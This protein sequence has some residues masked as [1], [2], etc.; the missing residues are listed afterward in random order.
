MMWISIDPSKASTGVALWDGIE[1]KDSL[2]IKPRG[3]KGAY[4]FENDVVDCRA[5]AY[6]K[7][8]GTVNC[9]VER[10]FIER[11][12]GGMLNAVRAQGWMCGYIAACFELAGMSAPEE[13]VVSEWRR[14]ITEDCGISWPANRDRKK[15]LAID[16][17]KQL[18]GRT[19]DNDDE[20]DA[21]LLGRAC[22]RMFNIK[23]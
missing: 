12:A 11:G 16:L 6:G 21:I 14:V 22:I 18:Y 20:A 10:A 13:V 15:A 8:R 17:V 7:L 3:T 1:L 2:V 23:D 5:I 19:V 9:P 4:Y